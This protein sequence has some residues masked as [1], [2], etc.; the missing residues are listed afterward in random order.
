MLDP[1]LRGSTSLGLSP[2]S[3]A[4][5]ALWN[6]WERAGPVLPEP[7]LRVCLVIEHWSHSV[8]PCLG[9][10]GQISAFEVHQLQL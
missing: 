3:V 5:S 9:L 6:R 4:S 7:G 10:D 2:R 1:G 8:S